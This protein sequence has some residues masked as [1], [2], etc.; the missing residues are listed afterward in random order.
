M[1][2]TWLLACLSG[3][4]CAGFSGPAARGLVNSCA[5]LSW[6]KGCSS[7]RQRKRGC[8]SSM[9]FLSRIQFPSPSTWLFSVEEPLAFRTWH[10]HV[11]SLCHFTVLP[12]CCPGSQTLS[13]QQTLGGCLTFFLAR[14]RK[15]ASMWK[16]LNGH[17]LKAARNSREPHRLVKCSLELRECLDLLPREFFHTLEHPQ[18]KPQESGGP[19]CH[20]RHGE[21]PPS[22]LPQCWR[23]LFR[24]YFS[25]SCPV[26]GSHWSYTHNKPLGRVSCHPFHHW[27][28]ALGFL[29][30]CPSQKHSACGR[31][32][33]QTFFI[34]TGR[35]DARV[36][37]KAGPV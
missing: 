33:T 13:S 3:T 11:G 32:G 27:Q 7:R 16:P 20:R 36:L 29:G 28:V 25:A 6:L 8:L 5:F 30:P 10:P 1:L 34:R 24:S 19:F 9:L 2:F 37:V 14:Q 15:W 23:H 17:S 18:R 21:K 12:T 31:R 26:W 22:D 35:W 4:T